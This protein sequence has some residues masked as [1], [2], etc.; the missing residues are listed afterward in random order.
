MATKPHH[1]QQQQHSQRWWWVLSTL[2]TNSTDNIISLH[3]LTNTH[4]SHLNSSLTMTNIL[5]AAYVLAVYKS[6]FIFSFFL[7]FVWQSSLYSGTSALIVPITQFL[8]VQWLP[9]TLHVLHLYVIVTVTGNWSRSTWRLLQCRDTLEVTWK[10]I[11]LHLYMKTINWGKMQ[12]KQTDSDMQ[13]ICCPLYQVVSLSSQTV[14]PVLLFCIHVW[15]H[16]VVKCRI[17]YH[18]VCPSVLTRTIHV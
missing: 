4:D 11:S 9:V 16:N 5:C 17:C 14:I 1:Q 8:L 7:L 10:D 2:S 6:D 12:G 15:L 3:W 18:N 13:W